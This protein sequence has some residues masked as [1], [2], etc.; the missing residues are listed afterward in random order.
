MRVTSLGS[1]P[2]VDCQGVAGR[3]FW[4][5]D[6]HRLSPNLSRLR[7]GPVPPARAASR[8]VQIEV[9]WGLALARGGTE[10]DDSEGSGEP[11]A[12]RGFAWWAFVLLACGQFT[13][14]LVMRGGSF[15]DL[16]RYA[17]GLE[18]MPFH[19]LG[20]EGDCR[21][22][23]RKWLV[24][25]VR[26]SLSYRDEKPILRRAVHRRLHRDA[27]CHTCGTFYAEALDRRC[28]LLGV[29]VSFAALHVLFQL[30]N[31]I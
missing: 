13:I 29:G 16:P 26:I 25:A 11:V 27:C 6:A 1:V 18:A 17:N 4:E 30:S 12:V 2:L 31:W 9:D 24:G 3:V 10:V 19:G 15:L 5:G 23:S 22:S 21:E 20:S 7:R 28:C 8:L 14:R